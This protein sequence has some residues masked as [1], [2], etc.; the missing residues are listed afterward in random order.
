MSLLKKKNPIAIN[1]NCVSGTYSH[2][3]E[4]VNVK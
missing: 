3:L 4:S 2:I 1:V